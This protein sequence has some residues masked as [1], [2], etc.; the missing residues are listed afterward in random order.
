MKKQI[1]IVKDR[2]GK[3]EIVYTVFNK[4]G[5]ELGT[6]YF[7]KPWKCLVW[8]QE[9][10]IMMSASCLEEVIKFMKERADKNGK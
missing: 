4:K 8:Q 9:E 3:G 2:F 10:D 6:I 1:K 5:G 7:H